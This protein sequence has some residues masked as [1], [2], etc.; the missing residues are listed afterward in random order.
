MQLDKAVYLM[1]NLFKPGEIVLFC[2]ILPFS[3]PP[4]L[5]LSMSPFFL[6]F[7]PLPEF[8]TNRNRDLRRG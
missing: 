5:P 7:L 1:K 6:S 3:L 4:F 8:K 2:L